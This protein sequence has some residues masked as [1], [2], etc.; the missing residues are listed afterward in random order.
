M[1]TRNLQHS[2]PVL[3]VV[4]LLGG[5]IA[6]AGQLV[7]TSGAWHADPV[8]DVP[9]P[10][11]PPSY[12]SAASVPAGTPIEIRLGETLSTKTTAAGERFTGSVVDPVVI[13]GRTVIPAGA[14]VQ[15][16]VTESLRSKRIGGRARMGL[17]LTSISLRG[18][19]RR[20]S[21]D[22]LALGKKQTT[23]DTATIAGATAGGAVLGRILGHR[24]GDEADG[25]LVGAAVGGAVGTGVALSN[26]AHVTLP[27]G[28]TLT[29]T[30][31][32]AV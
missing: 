10:V 3:V 8:L 5:V 20:I 15:G 19:Q 14:L 13:D 1:D 29:V 17:E 2:M 12:R 24:R 16:V 22:Y 28:T 21:G 30:L 9:Q 32:S 31:D 25:T 27:A 7:L 23:R 6:L 18:R 11:R 26:R 4:A